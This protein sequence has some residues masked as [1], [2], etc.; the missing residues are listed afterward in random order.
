M[1][2]GGGSGGHG[3]GG[4]GRCVRRFCVEF[5]PLLLRRHSCYVVP[6]VAN[7]ALFNKEQGAVH[8]RNS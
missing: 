7:L 5:M 1:V 4:G 2:V 8:T 6:S 3:G